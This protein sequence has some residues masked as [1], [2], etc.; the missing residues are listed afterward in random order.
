MAEE[1]FSYENDIAPLQGRNFGGGLYSP[2]SIRAMQT[3][4]LQNATQIKQ[5]ENRG[6]IA[7]LEYE[8]AKIQLDAVKREAQQ[9]TEMARLYP[10]I[11]QRITG[12]LDDPSKGAIEKL[13]ELEKARLEY[14]QSAIENPAFNRMFD[15]ATTTVRVRDE[16][17][18]MMDDTA[19]R[20]ALSGN[21]EGLK[22]WLGKESETESGK[23][24]IDMASSVSAQAAR[25]AQAKA[26]SEFGM[27][28]RKKVFETQIESEK[29]TRSRQISFYEKQL[30]SLEA[31]APPKKEQIEGMEIGSLTGK[32][33]APTTVPKPA[34][35]KEDRIE[36]E[37]RYKAL[38]PSYEDKSLDT[39]PDEELFRAT[40]KGT[41][42]A[43]RRLIGASTQ[44]TTPDFSSK[45]K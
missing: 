13:T 34:Y 21:T 10:T 17:Q 26:E 15:N 28:K 33:A 35:S 14:G 20:L 12:L 41:Q 16:R 27:T 45:F 38:N 43:L 37:E 18:K 25:E 5:M 36:L 11:S 40:Y 31:L 7:D 9:Q 1:A 8:R 44:S 29:D 19:S 6:R 3:E 42:N 22:S 39:V 24:Y 32:Q 4:A 30:A 23:R 2:T